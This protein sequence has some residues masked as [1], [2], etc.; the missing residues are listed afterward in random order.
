M[1]MPIERTQISLEIECGWRI[2]LAHVPEV[3][4]N[5]GAGQVN[6]L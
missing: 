2:G 3:V 1:V 4:V 6:G 5:V